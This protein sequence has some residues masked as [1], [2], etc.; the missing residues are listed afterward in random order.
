LG[1]G[2]LSDFEQNLVKNSIKELQDSIK[3]GEK[4]VTQ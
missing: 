2:K 3:K 1:L 4:F